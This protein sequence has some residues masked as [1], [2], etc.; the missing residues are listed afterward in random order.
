MFGP[1][2]PSISS[3]AFSAMPSCPRGAD[4]RRLV[5][6]RAAGR[7]RVTLGR[8]PLVR[9]ADGRW[10]DSDGDSQ[11]VPGLENQNWALPPPALPLA[12]AVEVDR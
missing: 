8:Q 10:L 9:N 11:P 7:R 3:S 12:L 1:P 6:R 5:G 2:S 4:A